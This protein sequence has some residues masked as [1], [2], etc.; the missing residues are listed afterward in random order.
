MHSNNEYMEQSEAKFTSCGNGAHRT[1][2]LGPGVC[3]VRMLLD[4]LIDVRFRWPV[5]NYCYSYEAFQK[6]VKGLRKPL[7]TIPGA[8]KLTAVSITSQD[9]SVMPEESNVLIEG[10]LQEQDRGEISEVMK[11]NANAEYEVLVDSAVEV[12]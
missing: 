1:G 4:V 11:S 5:R 2:P 3:N 8:C 7:E 10:A 9:R 6:D 12:E